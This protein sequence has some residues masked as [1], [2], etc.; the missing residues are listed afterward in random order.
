M[1]RTSWRIALWGA[2]VL[3]LG[4]VFIV[5]ARHPGKY[6]WDLQT[7]YYSALA[8]RDG[9]NPYDRDAVSA[10]AQTP[11]RFA[12]VYPP[13]TLPLMKVL[14]ALP[15]RDVSF[16]WLALKALLLS[17][18]LWVWMRLL[19]GAADPMYL[20]VAVLAFHGAMLAD[21][22]AGNIS[23]LE[24]V[25]LW[26]GFLML[27]KNM[28]AAAL[29][30]AAASFFKVSYALFLVLLVI[31]PG[32]RRWRAL[33]LGLFFVVVPMV[34]SALLTPGLFQ[35]FLANAGALAGPAERGDSNPCLFTFLLTL[36]D[37]VAQATGV[38]VPDGAVIGL[39]LLHAVA[40]L[41]VA[42][43]VLRRAREGASDPVLTA[44][45]VLTLLYPLCVPRFKDYAYILLIPGALSML[46]GAGSGRRERALLIFI[47]VVPTFTLVSEL[48]PLTEYYLF[49]AGYAL[50]WWFV[51]EKGSDGAPAVRTAQA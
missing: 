38:A 6:Q 13:H 2:L 51:A 33:A 29:L 20:L 26:S 8:Y 15:L 10:I 9:N 28:V 30:I 46:M 50:F 24:Q 21:V 40:V 44:V 43:R 27:R 42:W 36:R 23:L 19:P 16:L 4:G 5:I 41:A 48:L 14:T 25:L 32:D 7:Y 17:V 18:L 31:V 3:L 45:L 35:A 22:I 12:Y 37:V 39:F 34:M 11:M 47:L 49:F 1:Q